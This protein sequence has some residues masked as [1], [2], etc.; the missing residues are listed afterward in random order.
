MKPYTEEIPAT[1][2]KFDMVPIPGGTFTMGSPDEREGPQGRRRPAARG[3]R[4][5]RSGWASAKSPGT[6]TS[7]GAFELDM[8]RRKLKQGRA[9]RLRQAG[10]RRRPAHQAL[11]RHDLRHG[12]G[13]L[14]GHL[15]DPVRRQDVLQVAL[16]QDRPL[17]SPAD[18]G[19]VGI[20]LP[21]RHDDRLLASATI[22]RSSAT[23]PGTSTTATTS[24]TRSARRSRIPGACTTCTATWPNGCSTSTCPTSTSSSPAR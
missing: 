22:R 14:S 1:D 20:R 21:R 10:R 5:S 7:C 13:R 4:S 6:S 12:Q 19:R 2:V 9:D 24:T 16:G 18:R 15:H 3:R 17:L 11:H 8:Q 23:T